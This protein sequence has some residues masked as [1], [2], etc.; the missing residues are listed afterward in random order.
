MNH[1]L[2]IA[3]DVGLLRNS[4]LVQ[5]IRAYQSFAMITPT[6]YLISTP[7]TVVSVRDYLWSGLVAGDK[8]FVGH[9]PAPSA[10]NGLPNEVANWIH[11]NQG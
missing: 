6:C 2:I 1:I 8:L 9:A 11:A 10:W 5:R 7:N 3:F 4:A